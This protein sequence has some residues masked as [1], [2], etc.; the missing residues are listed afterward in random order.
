MFGGVLICGLVF[1]LLCASCWFWLYRHNGL[2]PR[3]LGSAAEYSTNGPSIQECFSQRPNV[4]KATFYGEVQ[5]SRIKFHD[6]IIRKKNISLDGIGDLWRQELW[7]YKN[8]IRSHRDTAK[9][10]RSFAKRQRET[11]WVKN[12]HAYSQD[13]CFLVK[14]RFPIVK[15]NPL[16]ISKFHQIRLP[17]HDRSL[18]LH[19]FGLISYLS[20]RT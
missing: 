11:R 14:F 2:I 6:L 9:L 4:R 3:F 15:L 17:I 18:P 1:G 16:R 7:C 19:Q 13:V 5:K 8:L 10:Y 20:E 12:I